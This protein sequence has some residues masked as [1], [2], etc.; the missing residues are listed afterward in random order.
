[1]RILARAVRRCGELLALNP[2][3]G[4]RRRGETSY[5]KDTPAMRALVRAV[6]NSRGDHGPRRPT[7]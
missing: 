5:P 2:S 7:G 4:A 1:M 6:G 3:E